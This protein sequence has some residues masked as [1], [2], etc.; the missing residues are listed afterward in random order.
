M[1]V[2]LSGCGL[3]GDDEDDSAAQV[4]ISGV[5][6][7]FSDGSPLRGALVALEPHETN[8]EPAPFFKVT[9]TDGNGRYTLELNKE[10]CPGPLMTLRA[11]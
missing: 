9:F 7:N 10:R 3:F 8:E 2:V 5:V 6:S 4:R 1:L 11:E